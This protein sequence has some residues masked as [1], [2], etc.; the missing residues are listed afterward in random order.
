MIFNLCPVSDYMHL[1]N[2]KTEPAQQETN[3]AAWWAIFVP[4]AIHVSVYQRHLS[5][6]TALRCSYASCD[7]FHGGALVETA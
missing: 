6:L 1:V 7:A 2:G 3:S 4:C 5:D